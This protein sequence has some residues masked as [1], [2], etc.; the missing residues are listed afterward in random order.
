MQTIWQGSVSVVL[1]M[2]GKTQV[3][4]ISQNN[5]RTSERKSEPEVAEKKEEVSMIMT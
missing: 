1:L 2:L 3:R 5:L 4:R